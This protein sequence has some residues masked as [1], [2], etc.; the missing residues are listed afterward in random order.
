M[1]ELFNILV[2]VD[3]I[4]SVNNMYEIRNGRIHL[5]EEV[6]LFKNKV[7]NYLNDNDIK[8]NYD[9][10][11]GI[12]VNFAF[13]LKK[14]LL[15]RDVDNMIKATQDAVFSYLQINDAYITELHAVKII[16]KGSSEFIKIQVL[17][18]KHSF[19]DYIL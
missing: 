15:K 12:I 18:S 10:T 2:P 1:S 9:F 14:S 5:V 17:E 11:K 16:K 4:P 19:T 6:R 8:V 7:F 13:I 3:Y